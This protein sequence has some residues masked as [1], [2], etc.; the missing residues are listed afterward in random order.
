[1]IFH[2]LI[3]HCKLHFLHEFEIPNALRLLQSNGNQNIHE[4]EENAE[5]EDNENENDSSSE[6]NEDLRQSQ[7]SEGEVQSVDSSDMSDENEYH[8]KSPREDSE[9]I[10]GEDHSEEVEVTNSKPVTYHNYECGS[11]NDNLEC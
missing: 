2:T 1:M 5:N 6:I 4:D 11:S 7:N 10:T 9:N 8:L 3:I